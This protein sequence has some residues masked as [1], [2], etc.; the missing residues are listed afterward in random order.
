MSRILFIHPDVKLV[1]IYRRHL[2]PH[3]NVDSAQDGLA[4]L[5]KIKSFGPRLIVSDYNLGHLSGLAL[6]QYVRRHPQMFATPF[7]FLTHAE[8]PHDA[9]GLGA[10]GWVSQKEQGVQ[11]LLAHIYQHRKIFQD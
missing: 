2:D 4:G 11:N 6:L 10:S 9:L 3:F 7:I 8:M 5:K 1:D